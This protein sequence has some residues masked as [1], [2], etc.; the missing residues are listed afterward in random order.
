MESQSIG[1]VTTPTLDLSPYLLAIADFIGMNYPLFLS[2]LRSI[3][4]II[5]GISIVLCVFFFVAI[6]ITVEKLKAI[7][8]KESEIY[9]AKVDMG[10]NTASIPTQKSNPEIAKKWD[11][12]L[13]HVESEN[14][15][16]WRQAVMESDI[17]LDDVLTQL[18]YMGDGVGGK[19]KRANKADFKTLDDAWEAHKVRNQIAHAGSDYPFSQFD[20]RKVIQQYKK[21]FEEFFYI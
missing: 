13:E 11:K 10:Y 5:I 15:N 2:T 7:R 18:G 1:I 12:V 14:P 9:D 21:V 16:D 6:I 8:I 3:F 17:I 19:L 20:A 4:G